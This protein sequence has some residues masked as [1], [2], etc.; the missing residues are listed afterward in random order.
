M[1]AMIFA[2]GMG[3]RLRPLTDNIPK[4]LVRVGGIPLL[5]RIILKLTASGF[6]DITINIHHRGQQIIDFLQANK[7][8]GQH[9]NSSIQE[10]AFV[11]PN[12]F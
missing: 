6:N 3:T 7:N 8:F 12:I 10:E 11:M 5:Q 1:K 4:A 9:I 2:A